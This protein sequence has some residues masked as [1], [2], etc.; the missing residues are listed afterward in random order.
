MLARSCRFVS[1]DFLIK[2]FKGGGGGGF[3]PGFWDM[4]WP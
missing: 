2:Y 3:N 4:S 1:L